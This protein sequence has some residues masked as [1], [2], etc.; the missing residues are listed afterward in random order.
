MSPSVSPSIGSRPPT[1]ILEEADPVL[2]YIQDSAFD[3]SLHVE[4]EDHDRVFLT[5]PVDSADPLLDLHR[6]P[7]KVVVHKEVAELEVAALSAGF[8]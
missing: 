2:E 7:R 1:E 8:R 5:D 4:V 3:R 6:V